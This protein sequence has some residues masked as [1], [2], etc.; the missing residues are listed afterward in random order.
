MTRAQPQQTL[1]C[2]PERVNTVPCCAICNQMKRTSSVPDFV[3]RARAINAHCPVALP[4]QRPPLPKAFGGRADLR[5]ARKTKA[6]KLTSA[7]RRA[8]QSATCYLCGVQPAGGVDRVDSF[9]DYVTDNVRSCCKGCNYLKKDLSPQ[10][11][12]VH[13]A[14]IV[15]HTSAWDT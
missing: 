13:V 12:C 10:E 4:G 8:L 11:V 1:T 14:Y 6:D 3:E 2:L 15:R 7:Q 9:G 5:N